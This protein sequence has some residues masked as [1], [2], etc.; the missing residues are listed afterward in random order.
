M[1]RVDELKK[2]QRALYPT[3]RAFRMPFGGYFE[4]LNN[5]W[6][7]GQAR[8]LDDAFSLLTSLL[9]DNDS[10]T[11]DDA[12]QWER[13]LGLTTNESVSLTD[14]KLAISR[15]LAH[16]GTVRARQHYVYLEGQLR[17]AGFDVYVTENRFGNYAD[18]FTWVTPESLFPLEGDEL[19]TNGSFVT[20]TDW[21]F[22]AGTVAINTTSQVLRYTAAAPG[23]YAEQTL[24]APISFNSGS[25]RV[26]GYLNTN[27]ADIRIEF[28]DGT[29][30]MLEQVDLVGAGTTVTADVDTSAWGTDAEFIR[31]I[32]LSDPDGDIE[33]ISVVPIIPISTYPGLEENYYGIEFTNYVVNHID[34]TRELFWDFGANLKTTFFVGGADIFDTT[35]QF[36]D[37]DADRV[38]E[39]RELILKLKPVQT[40]AFLLINEV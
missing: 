11:T 25:Y 6:A 37:I 36:V 7:T 30:T 21:T 18:G 32:N 33:Y 40:K 4:K 35:K 28:Y 17:D 34:E 15:K 22:S 16:P 29:L 12:Q 10:F 5:A 9:P 20:N 23:D 39:L 14:R 19:I 1:A 2:L 27:I 13:R 8:F 31:I 24:S 3:G 26:R 38:D